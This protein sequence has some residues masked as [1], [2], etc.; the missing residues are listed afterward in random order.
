MKIK[1][2]FIVIII[3]S[4]IYLFIYLVDHYNYFWTVVVSIS[5]Y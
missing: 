5:Y 4:S 1:Y 2:F 3:G